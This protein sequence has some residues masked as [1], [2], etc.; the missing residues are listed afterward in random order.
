[1]RGA[2][3]R[4]QAVVVRQRV[5]GAV[6]LSPGDIVAGIHVAVAVVVARQADG[7][8]LRSIDVF[9]GLSCKGIGKPAGPVG[10]P[11]QLH[12]I[13][14]ECSRIVDERISAGRQA[15]GVGQR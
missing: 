7:W 1:M 4:T 14:A 5:V 3:R 6:V 9:V 15:A 2:D 13:A 12:K 11:R 8:S 10:V